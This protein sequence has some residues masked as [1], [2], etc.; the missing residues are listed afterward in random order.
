MFQFLASYCPNACI[1]ITKFISRMLSLYI[2][3]PSHHK[4]WLQFIT[5]FRKGQFVVPHTTDQS[6]IPAL[7]DSWVTNT[8]SVKMLCPQKNCLSLHFHKN[9]TCLDVSL[10]RICQVFS[11]SPKT[12]CQWVMTN[13]CCMSY[14]VILPLITLSLHIHILYHPIFLG[15]SHMH[16]AVYVS[17][18]YLLQKPLHS[19][20]LLLFMYYLKSNKKSHHLLARLLH[21][22]SPDLSCVPASPEAPIY[23]LFCNFKALFGCL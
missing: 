22:D 1:N 19:D 6:E 17:F 12:V 18:P 23:W 16:T 2:F 10:L 4:K 15:A 14:M 9:I 20:S 8:P 21:F 13:C 3:F 7:Q 11:V 5:V